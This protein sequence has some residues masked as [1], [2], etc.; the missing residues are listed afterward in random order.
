MLDGLPNLVFMLGFTDG[1]WTIG[2]DA[3]AMI[4]VRVLRDMPRTQDASVTP[5]GPRD[6]TVE[7]RRVW[8]TDAT[9][10]QIADHRLPVYGVKG[11]WGPRRVSPFAGYLHSR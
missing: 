2:A 4:L 11:P 6:A 5:R 10:R 3:A 8:T 9:Y 1:T 7:T